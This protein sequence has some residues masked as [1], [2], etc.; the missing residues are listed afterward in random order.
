MAW[1]KRDDTDLIR[2]WKKAGGEKALLKR[3]G[4]AQKNK[5][6]R[7]GRRK[8]AV[9]Y[10]IDAVL[11]PYLRE[12]SEQ[13]ER[14]YGIPPYRTIKHFASLPER[15]RKKLAEH[16]VNVKPDIPRFGASTD[17]AAHRWAR[18]IKKKT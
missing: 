17:A 16:G 18:E 15:A 11:V 10:P 12:L 7:G 13:M 2:L 3:L 4:A 8:G 6:R 9:S 1:G 5:P 14:L